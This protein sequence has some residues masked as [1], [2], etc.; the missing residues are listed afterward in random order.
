MV[1]RIPGFGD[2]RAAFLIFFIF[3][4]FIL[5]LLASGSGPLLE[6]I[7]TKTVVTPDGLLPFP[8]VAVSTWIDIHPAVLESG[9]RYLKSVVKFVYFFSLCFFLCVPGSRSSQ[10]LNLQCQDYFF[11]PFI[12]FV[13]Y[14]FAFK[15]HFF[16]YRTLSLK[17]MTVVFS[18]HI[19]SVSQVFKRTKHFL[20]KRN[21]RNL[22][23]FWSVTGST[24]ISLHR[25]LC[26]RTFYIFL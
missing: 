8:A 9:C 24:H 19:Y 23:A 7:K 6:V 15:V 17:P 5:F 25:V 26:R 14:Y 1:D 13:I 2:S 20:K 22:C 21:K 18:K 3:G 12:F 11:C 16:L 10:W 4:C